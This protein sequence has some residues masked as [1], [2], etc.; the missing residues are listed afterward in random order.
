[1]SC[2]PECN[3]GPSTGLPG[4]ALHKTRLD[5][6]LVAELQRQGYAEEGIQKILGENILRVWI[7]VEEVALQHQ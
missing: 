2:E 3:L 6:N 4:E 7:E 5:A 1:M